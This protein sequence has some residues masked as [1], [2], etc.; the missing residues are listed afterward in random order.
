MPVLRQLIAVPAILL[1]SQMVAFDPASARDDEAQLWIL[2]TAKIPLTSDISAIAEGGV[3]YSESADGLAQI[4]ARGSVQ[5]AVSDDLSLAIGYGH[6]QNYQS[7]HRTGTEE[8]PFQQLNWT[9]GKALGGEWGSR[10]Q[11]EERMFSESSRWDVRLRER[12][13]FRGAPIGSSSIRPD[14]SGEFLF[15]LNRTS[16]GQAAGINSI[17]GKAGLS[18]PL[19]KHLDISLAYLGLYVP[20]SGEDRML[21]VALTGMTY[22]F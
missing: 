14:F 13:S 3:R 11:L 16:S 21:H 1:F 7:Q 4:F 19:A 17:R 2:P 5:V 8:R 22:R 20:R 6:F 18:A 9:I 15:N 12:I 10:T